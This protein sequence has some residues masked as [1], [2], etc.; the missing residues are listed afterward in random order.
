MK[1]ARRSDTPPCVWTVG[2]L[3]RAP[4]QKVAPH[5]PLSVALLS[6]AKGQ[7]VPV[8]LGEQDRLVGLL[9]SSELS[10]RAGALDGLSVA[11]VM[12]TRFP[13]VRAGDPLW[14]AY[15]KL[16][17]SQLFAIPV[18]NRDTDG[19][20]GLVS[21]ADIRRAIRDGGQPAPLR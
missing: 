9:T 15:E 7:V 16:H 2:Q 18:V 20:D 3:T 17:R 6:V 13:I 11:H 14:V 1:T 19:L 10:G 21:L 8:V 12:R 5:D 4:T